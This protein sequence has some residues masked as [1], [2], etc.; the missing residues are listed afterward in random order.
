MYVALLRKIITRGWR[1]TKKGPCTWLIVS[2]RDA[3]YFKD[4]VV[5]IMI[6]WVTLSYLPQLNLIKAAVVDKEWKKTLGWRRSGAQQ[7]KWE[8]EE[9]IIN[10]N[11]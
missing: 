7:E 10:Q 11:S 5:I 1:E 9:F 6:L 2:Y 4:I 8:E 3:N